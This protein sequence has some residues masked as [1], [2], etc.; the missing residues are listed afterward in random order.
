MLNWVAWNRLF[1]CIKI[2]LTLSNLQ[3]L[4]YHKTQTNKSSFSVL[5]TYLLHFRPSLVV[6][7][8]ISFYSTIVVTFFFSCFSILFFSICLNLRSYLINSFLSP[9]TPSLS[10]SSSSYCL[11]RSSSF[12]GTFFRPNRNCPLTKRRRQTLSKKINGNIFG[13]IDR[14]TFRS[15]SETL[16]YANSQKDD[17]SRW[18]FQNFLFF[19]FSFSILFFSFSFSL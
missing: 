18:T 2:D 4:M 9:T 6:L 14:W 11:T 15:T 16:D 19:Y 12:F 5:F 1:I 10:S 8:L 13:P 17:V 3:G 7:F